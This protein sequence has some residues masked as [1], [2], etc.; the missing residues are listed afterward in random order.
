MAIGPHDQQVDVIRLGMAR[1]HLVRLAFFEVRFHFERCA[2]RQVCG[3]FKLAARFERF[4][5]EIE[6]V[7][8]RTS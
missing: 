6:G 4:S 5:P 8:E 1:N 3:R 7:T 2:S